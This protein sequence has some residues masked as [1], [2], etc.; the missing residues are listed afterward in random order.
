MLVAIDNISS[1]AI[2]GALVFQFIQVNQW[3]NAKKR[4]IN[5]RYSATI[6]TCLSKCE[7]VIKQ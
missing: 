4:E 7:P 3:Q 6:L 1:G 2:K 5:M